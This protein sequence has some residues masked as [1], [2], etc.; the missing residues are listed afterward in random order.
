[1]HPNMFAVDVL[2]RMAVWKLDESAVRYHFG[3]YSNMQPALLP[4]VPDL[5]RRLIS[6]PRGPIQDGTPPEHLAIIN[7]MKED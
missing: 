5:L 4:F 3:K 6:A 7:K 1:M 2:M